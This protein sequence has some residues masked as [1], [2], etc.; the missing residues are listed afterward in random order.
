MTTKAELLAEKALLKK[1]YDD[2][3][4][5]QEENPLRIHTKDSE[6]IRKGYE[7]MNARIALRRK[8]QNINDELKTFV[9]S[10]K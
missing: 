7:R 3:L 5:S 1:E 9:K 10:R 8:L 4:K 6:A 2:L